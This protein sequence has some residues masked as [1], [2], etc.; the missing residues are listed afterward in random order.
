MFLLISRVLLDDDVMLDKITHDY[1]HGIML[2]KDV[3]NILIEVLT[4]M[5]LNHQIE[6]AKVDDKILNNF[7]EIK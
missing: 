5:V 3:K 6:R 7:F 1:G 4:N 2:T